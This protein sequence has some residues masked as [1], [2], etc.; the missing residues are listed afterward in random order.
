MVFYA[1]CGTNYEDAV[2]IDN[3]RCQTTTP[4]P[5]T[6]EPTTPEPTMP[7]PTTPEPTTPEPAYCKDYSPCSCSVDSNQFSVSCYGV[8]VQTVRDVFLRV[9]DPE[10]YQLEFSPPADDTNTF[11]LPEDFLGNTSVTV[12]IQIDG[13]YNNFKYPNLVIDPLA[14][15]ASQN[16]LTQF[17]VSRLNFGLKNAFNFLNGFNKLEELTFSQITNLTAFQYLPPLPSI[18]KLSIG[19]CPSELNQIPFPDLSPAKLNNLDLRTNEIND[20]TADKIVAKLAASSSADSLVFL[21]LSFNYLTRIP[22]QVGSAFPKLK[23]V[24]L[25][26][27]NILHIPSASFTFAY[28]LKSLSLNDN[29]IKT[30]ESGAFVGI[31]RFLSEQE[32]IIIRVL[33]VPIG[34]FTMTV[35]DL[36]FTEL[37]VFEEGVFK[38][39]LQQMVS[40]QPPIGYVSVI[41]SIYY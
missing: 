19:N 13:N 21:D 24:V 22:S 31:N 41:E 11:S 38:E 37:T 33:L 35:I 29:K 5:T 2:A 8:S 15:R 26:N 39:M 10:I 34:N 36:Y 20:E 25:R 28:P 40:V 27:N 6:P 23:S 12:E 18:Q 7:E 14:F 1:Y 4:K 16:S 30:I 9:N 17:G 3:I 32:R